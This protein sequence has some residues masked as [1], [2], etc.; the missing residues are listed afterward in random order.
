MPFWGRIFVIG[1]EETGELLR[2]EYSPLKDTEWEPVLPEGEAVV[3]SIP[4]FTANW[5]TTTV[6]RSRTWYTSKKPLI[7][8]FWAD[9]EAARRGEFQL[10]VSNRKPREAKCLITADEESPAEMAEDGH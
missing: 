7:E 9:V 3:E 10:P 8:S 5:Y 2:Y 6:G 1:E 4:W